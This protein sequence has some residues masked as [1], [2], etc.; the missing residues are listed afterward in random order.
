M[1]DIVT[2]VDADGFKSLLQQS[3]YLQ[4]ETKFLYDG[5]KKGFDIGYQGNREVQ[6]LSPNLKFRQ[7][8]DR[9]M[10]WNKVMKEVKLQCYAGPFSKIP[11]K[12]FIQSPI[13]LV[14]KDGGCDI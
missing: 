6:M 8:G 7:G 5:F 13:G 4:E 1:T 14:P 3:G 11:F 2:P 9:I 10:L 12:H